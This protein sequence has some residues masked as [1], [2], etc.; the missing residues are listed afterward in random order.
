MKQALPRAPDQRLCNRCRKETEVI[1]YEQSS[2][3]DV[4]EVLCIGH[5]NEK[6]GLAGR[7]RTSEVSLGGDGTPAGA[8]TFAVTG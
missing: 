3:R 4:G 7:V 2:R 1:G 5:K 8:E 6:S